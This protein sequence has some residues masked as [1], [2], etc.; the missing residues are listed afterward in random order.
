MSATREPVPST[1]PFRVAANET[2]TPATFLATESTPLIISETSS[3]RT[4][5]DEE[6]SAANQQNHEA[7]DGNEGLVLE[8]P[9]GWQRGTCIVLSM[10]AL[11]FLQGELLNL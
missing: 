4:I 3:S 5:R 1:V 9:L 2:V 6:S 11:I 7:G 8:Q 10:W